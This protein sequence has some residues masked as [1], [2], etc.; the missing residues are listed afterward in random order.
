MTELAHRSD[1]TPALAGLAKALAAFQ[2]EMPTVAKSHTAN[3]GQYSYTYAALADVQGEAMPLLTKHGLSF[4]CCPSRTENGFELVGIL[5]HE[6]G[7]HLRGSLPLQSGNMQA[8]GSSI[9]YGRRYLFGCMTG[10]VTDDDDDGAAATRPTKAARK[11]APARPPAADGKAADDAPM[12]DNAR[13]R[14]FALFGECGISNED[15]QRQFLT[16]TLGR[17]VE[18]RSSLTE[19]EARTAWKRLRAIQAGTDEWPE[20]TS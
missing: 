7:E 17:L 4:T 20:A 5:L 18:S 19:G 16:D 13:G 14:L 8:I 2:A 3:T 10:V 12:T 9:T 6:S 1:T 11:T 15:D